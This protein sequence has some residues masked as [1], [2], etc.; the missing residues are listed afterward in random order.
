MSQEW[1]EVSVCWAGEKGFTG[2]NLNGGSV[3]M[4]TVDGRSG[5]SPMEMLLLGMAGCSGI[6]VIHI[7]EKKRF[8]PEKFE[9]RVRG[10]RADD[11]PRVY[12]EIEIE[13]LLWA[14]DINPKALEQAIRLSEDKYCSA[15]AMLSKSA[16]IRSSYRLLAPGEEILDDPD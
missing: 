12:T 16:N 2:K 9:I 11:H 15:S 14:Q 7:L 10:K 3:Q 6:D 1:K 8:I 4:G 5:V 13:Y